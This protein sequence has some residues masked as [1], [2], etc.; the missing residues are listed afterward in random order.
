MSYA[1]FAEHTEH[2]IIN[3]IPYSVTANFV[4]N[5]ICI[6]GACYFAKTDMSHYEKFDG[7]MEEFVTDFI[8]GQ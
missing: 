6:K 7:N 1:Q 8:G 4:N 2:Y 3:G 5:T